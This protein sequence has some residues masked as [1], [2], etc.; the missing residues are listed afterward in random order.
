MNRHYCDLSNGYNHAP[1]TT[2]PMAAST[3]NPARTP[4]LARLLIGLLFIVILL[5]CVFVKEIN[6]NKNEIRLK[7]ECEFK[8]IND[9]FDIYDCGDL[10]NGY[11][12]T[13]YATPHPT[14]DSCAASFEFTDSSV[15]SREQLDLESHM[16]GFDDGGGGSVMS[17]SNN[18]IGAT[19]PNGA[20][21]RNKMQYLVCSIKYSK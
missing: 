5:E 20:T 15:E 6:E 16:G 12:P 1:P 4:R 14:P 3:E 8:N 13:T 17:S 10:F 11:L 2:A 9:N 19:S 21:K 18:A 7:L